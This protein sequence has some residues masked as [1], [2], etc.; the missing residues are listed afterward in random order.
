MEA[1]QLD[2]VRELNTL[3]T[4]LG[5][6]LL[7]TSNGQP[8]TRGSMGRQ[9]IGMGLSKPSFLKDMHDVA[10]SLHHK[11]NSLAQ[12]QLEYRKLSGSKAVIP[13]TNLC[14][15]APCGCRQRQEAT[16]LSTKL[17]AFIL[18]SMSVSRYTHHPSCPRYTP[19]HTKRKRQFEITFI[20]LRKLLTTAV[21]AGLCLTSGAGGYSI[22][23]IFQYFAMIDKR[24]S[25]AFRLMS[26]V[27]DVFWEEVSVG[28]RTLQL[29][30]AGSITAHALSRLKDIY[31]S[32]TALPTDV[33]DA[34]ETLV[35]WF[36]AEVRYPL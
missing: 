17:S 35:D 36:M 26:F 6:V 12:Q 29:Q 18:T 14:N 5:D 11:S 3:K 21:S 24:I 16:H 22:S 7:H 13:E 31:A 15:L 1:T 9:I 8:L 27:L 20:G 23:P 4:L 28:E 33:N 34:G 32:R 30:K 25:P 2:T 19:E 10:D